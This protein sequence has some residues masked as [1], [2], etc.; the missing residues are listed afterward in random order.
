[1]TDEKLW[2]GEFLN[3]RLVLSVRHQAVTV[4]A[5]T[6]MQGPQGSYVYVLSDDNTTHRRKVDVVATQDGRSVISSGLRAG[7]R[8]V[9][10]GQYRLTDGAKVKVGDT[11][12]AGQNPQSS[13]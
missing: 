3:A 7:E 6:V 13:Q 5:E 2:P 1:N 4:T 12:Q 10:E 9:V 11:Q 8:V